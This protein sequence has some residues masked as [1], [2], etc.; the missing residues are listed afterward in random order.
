MYRYIYTYFQVY[1]CIYHLYIY[2]YVNLYVYLYIHM[3]FYLYRPT[4]SACHFLGREL[5]KDSNG[6]QSSGSKSE[7]LPSGR[8]GGS[9]ADLAVHIALYPA[10]SPTESGSGRGFSWKGRWTLRG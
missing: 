1:I 7:S 4:E 8:R 6:L 10:N 5:N 9:F 2:M 3:R